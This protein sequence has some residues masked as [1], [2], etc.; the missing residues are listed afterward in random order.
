MVTAHDVTEMTL[1]REAVE[2][3]RD[4][5]AKQAQEMT[6]L[7]EQ[8]EISRAEA[9]QANQELGRSSR[10]FRLLAEN[11]ENIILVRDRTGEYPFVS[12]SVKRLTGYSS[13]EIRARGGILQLLHPEDSAEMRLAHDMFDRGETPD[14]PE[15][16]VRIT[17]RSGE[18]RWHE[19]KFSV[20]GSVD[21][22]EQQ[23]LLISS[24]DVTD[25]VRNQQ[26]L[27]KSRIAMERQAAELLTMAQ[28]QE[29]SARLFRILA[30]NTNDL[31]AYRNSKGVYTYFSPAAE[32]LTGYTPEEL[33]E[34]ISLQ[35]LLDPSWHEVATM[36]RKQHDSGESIH[37]GPEITQI[38]TKQGEDRHLQVTISSIQGPDDDEREGV[39]LTFHNVTELVQNQNQL[40]KLAE[41]LERNSQLFKLLAPNTNDFIAYRNNQGNYTYFSPATTRLTGYTPEEMLEMNN[42]LPLL[43]PSWHETALEMRARL[44]QGEN[45]QFGPEVLKIITKQGEERHL[46]VTVSSMKGP[47][48]GDGQGALMAF[49]DVTEMIENQ[50]ELEK[51]RDQLSNLAMELEAA[52]QNVEQN[53]ETIECDID[54]AR[55]M[56]EAIVPRKFPVHPR[57]DVDASMQA[58]R[59][60]GGDFYEFLQLDD[61]RVG[62][63]IADVSDKGVPAAFFMAISRTLLETAAMSGRGPAAVLYDVNI[64]LLDQNP[65]FLFVTL[66]YGILDLETGVMTY[67]NGGHNPPYIVRARGAVE[68]LKLTDDMI[69]GVVEGISY[70]EKTA[71]LK[72]GDALVLFTDGVTEAFNEKKK[73][74]GERRLKDTIR[75]TQNLSTKEIVEKVKADVKEFAGGAE[76]SDDLTC[77]TLKFNARGKIKDQVDRY[78]KRAQAVP[79]EAYVEIELVNNESQIAPVHDQINLFSETWGIPADVQFQIAVSVEEYIVNLFHY[80]YADTH[81]HLIHITMTRTKSGLA[82][83][84]FDDGQPF[85]PL[86]APEVDLTSSIEDRQ[87]GGLGIH[88]IRAYM[89]QLSYQSSNSVNRFSMI[90]YLD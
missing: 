38:S 47:G 36:L 70:S 83:E 26:E 73:M 39:L 75:K 28:D 4:K 81:R 66:F 41:E 18:E 2:E 11:A 49:H 53:L 43:H 8:L 42:I 32:S 59:Q 30:E 90:K 61:H 25:L 54:L 6:E 63:A 88:I 89:D 35:P 45:I 5:L 19:I 69:L 52:K 10:L 84:I 58:A 48:E 74:F 82:V 68:E 64:R 17:T 24:H 65:L 40:A 87:I 51:S 20:V 9:E 50:N 33:L 37:F 34:I 79:P 13:E 23:S 62:F 21:D 67:S 16:L 27:E 55:S 22:L 60:V 56:Q 12:P 76:Q 1:A 77:L 46:E 29:R 31:I 3:S 72:D 57:Y 44:D 71:R 7:A 85:N 78:S 14:F 86:T 80:G 15:D